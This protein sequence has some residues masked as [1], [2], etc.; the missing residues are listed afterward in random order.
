MKHLNMNDNWKFRKIEEGREWVSVYLPHDAQLHEK[1]SADMPMDSGYFPGGKYQYQKEF[2]CPAEYAGKTVLLDFDGVYMN[3]KVTINGV[4]VA[5]QPYGYTQ[6]IVP[7]HPHLKAG[8][9]NTIEVIA[10]NSLFPNARWYTGSGIY[11][12][13]VIHVGSKQY[14]HPNGVKIN[15]LSYSPAQISIDIDSSFAQECTVKTDIHWDGKMIASAEGYH[16]TLTIPEAKLW[17]EDTPSLYT[18]HVQLLQEGNIMDETRIPFGIRKIEWDAAYGLKVNGNVVL[19]RGG[20][21]H[22]DNGLLGAAAPA[23]VE[24][25]KVRILKEAGFNALR[26]SHN[27]CSK[28]MLEACDRYG[29][30]MMDEFTDMWTQHKHKYDYATQFK[31]WYERDLSAM[32]AKDY[33]HPCVIMYSIGNEVGESATPEGIDYARKMTDLVH[34]LDDSR[35]VTCGINLLLNGLTAMGKGLYQGDTPPTAT[36][37]DSS[38]KEKASGSTFIN[39]VMGKMGGILNMVGRL[40]KFDMATKDVFEVLDIA[41]YNYG[42]GRYKVDPQKYPK[43]ITVGSE[44][45][46]PHLYKNWMSVKKHPNLIGDFMWTA[47]D[48]LGE[49]GIGTIGYGENSGV[50]KE[51]PMLLSGAG[52]IDITGECRPEVYWTQ[53]VW[54]LREAP[55]LAVEP[56]THAGEKST[57]SMWRITD[58]R[59]SWAWPGCEG[60]KTTVSVYSTAHHVVLLLNNHIIGKRRVKECKAVFKNIV[61]QQGELKAIAYDVSGKML[62]EDVLQSS[63][64][65]GALIIQAETDTFSNDNLVYVNLYMS[66]EVGVRVYN[67]D[68]QVTIDIQGGTLVGFG[69]ANPSPNQTYFDVTQSLYDGKVQAIIRPDAKGKLITIEGMT[70]SGIK[71]CV[72]IAR[73]TE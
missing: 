59:H 25:R 39:G 73:Q 27:M 24:E 37:Q 28:A 19:L 26:S 29:M 17:S 72:H 68:E 56:L 60:K 63:G 14:I 45:F 13:V 2:M 71:A 16:T 49:A 6:F 67:A 42:S 64:K 65:P 70:Q 11:R 38:G 61:Y 58:A 47:W 33:N 62:G 69:S 5:F 31:E 50:L 23:S 43:R 15:T 40:K 22:H 3:A 41:G 35:P 66:D 9:I 10:D 36:K 46:P 8:E 4:E 54:G 7:I 21:I 57:K 44:T 30:Y 55:Y 51:Y 20:C 48:Y 53:C 18:A 34:R 12:N 52:I 1:R 32:I